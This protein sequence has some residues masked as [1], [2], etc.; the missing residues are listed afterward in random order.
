[1]RAIIRQPTA[2]NQPLIWRTYSAQPKRRA[3]LIRRWGD[4]LQHL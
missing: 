4:P 1:M 3:S 2:T